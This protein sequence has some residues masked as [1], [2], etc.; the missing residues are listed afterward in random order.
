MVAAVPWPVLQ[1]PASTSPTPP[2]AVLL[3]NL[4]LARLPT[5]RPRPGPAGPGRLAVWSQALGEFGPGAGPARLAGRPQDGA[6]IYVTG[7]LF[8][9]IDYEL[10]DRRTAAG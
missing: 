3:L 1:R 5:P 7:G 9:G 6:L 8:G 2:R 10:A 4:D